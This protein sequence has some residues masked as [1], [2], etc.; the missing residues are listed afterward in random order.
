ME[1]CKT[2]P[3]LVELSFYCNATIIQGLA[4]RVKSITGDQASI[5]AKL[6][7]AQSLFA[8]WR[9]DLMIIKAETAHWGRIW[10]RCEKVVRG[11]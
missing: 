3:D 8:L 4:R 6:L 11:I 2:S 5:F 10:D 9:A 1:N 7:S